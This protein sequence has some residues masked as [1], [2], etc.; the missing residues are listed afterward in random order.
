ML[1]SSNCGTEIGGLLHGYQLCAATEGKSPNSVA[2]V[3]DSV[4]YLYD[5]LSSNGLSTD[6]TL[7]GAG[8]MRTF[9]LYLQQKRCFS[10]HPYSKAQQRGLSGHT[11]NTYMRSIRAFWSWLVEEEVIESNPFSR[12]KI[13]HPPKKIIATFSPYQIESLLGV[14]SS[15]AEGYRDVVIVLTLLDTGLRVNELVLMHLG[16]LTYQP[17]QNQSTSYKVI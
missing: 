7:I 15:S 9:I 2:I 17:S 14:M 16:V 12:L 4:T 6:V 1:A 3:T 10:N 11:I 8:E 13:P 5:F